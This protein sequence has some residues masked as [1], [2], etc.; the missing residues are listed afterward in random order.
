VVI[1]L[2]NLMAAGRMWWFL[3]IKATAGD[4]GHRQPLLAHGKWRFLR[5]K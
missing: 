1:L 4:G 3:R 5:G 2:S